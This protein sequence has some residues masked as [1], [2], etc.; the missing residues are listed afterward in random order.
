MPNAPPGTDGGSS[1]IPGL[2]FSVMAVIALSI[3]AAHAPPAFRLIGLFAAVFGSC[4]GMIVATA[5]TGSLRGRAIVILSVLLSLAGWC[6]T[7]GLSYS[8]YVD[9]LGDSREWKQVELVASAIREDVGDGADS[10]GMRQMGGTFERALAEKRQQ[11][12][13]PYY[14]AQRLRGL[15]NFSPAI[16]VACAILEL[17]VAASLGAWVAGAWSRRTRRPTSGGLQQS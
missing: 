13:L 9:R 16:G 7:T 2:L 11:A 5:A 15:G 4:V 10:E 14:L 1:A 3:A 6:I 8:R 17:A 12:Q